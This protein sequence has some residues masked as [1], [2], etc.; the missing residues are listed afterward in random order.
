M[1]GS[2]LAVSSASVSAGSDNDAESSINE[3]L[4]F[5]IFGISGV[6]KTHL[7]GT[8]SEC[9]TTSDVLVIDAEGGKATLL[10]NWRDR[11]DVVR[12]NSY[13]QLNIVYEFMRAHCQ[14]RDRYYVALR[15]VDEE[16]VTKLRIQLLKYEAWLKNLEGGHEAFPVDYPPRLYRLLGVDTLSELQ[17]YLMYHLTGVDIDAIKL[18]AEYKIPQIQDWGK[19]IEGIRLLVRVLR[20]LPIHLM[21]ISHDA[22]EKDALGAIKIMPNFSGK[23]LPNEI[24]AMMDVVGYLTIEVLPDGKEQRSLIVQPTGRYLAKSRFKKMGRVIINPTVQKMMDSV[25]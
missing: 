15:A 8:A 22:V 19:N 21:T 11:I 13:K 10:A 2:G 9:V 4:N 25:V 18:D 23:S 14:L 6:G 24:C 17:K 5:H 1:A 7:M 3:W 12:I 16:Q 20:D